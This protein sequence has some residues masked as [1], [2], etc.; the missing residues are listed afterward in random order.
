[1]YLS[2]L[3]HLL[4]LSPKQSDLSSEQGKSHI[5]EGNRKKHF[6]ISEKK[7]K[8]KKKPEKIQLWAWKG[9]EGTGAPVSLRS[10]AGSKLGKSCLKPG[11]SSRMSHGKRLSELSKCVNNTV[12]GGEKSV[13][14][15]SCSSKLNN[16]VIYKE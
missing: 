7:K 13:I 14:R 6:I 8:I 3:A 9:C 2:S 11:I 15:N 16:S 10:S 1:M 4:I 12:S 5:S